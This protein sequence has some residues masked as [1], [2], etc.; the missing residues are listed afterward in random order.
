MKGNKG[1]A[2]VQQRR[3]PSNKNYTF[4]NHKQDGYEAAEFP[5]EQENNEVR[6]CLHLL[7]L[8]KAKKMG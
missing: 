5:L 1:F 7:G 6:F 2:G 4:S 8:A 3:N